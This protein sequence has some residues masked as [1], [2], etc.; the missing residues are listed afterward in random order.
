MLQAHEL[1]AWD[2]LRVVKIKEP[3]T[4]HTVSMSAGLAEL[5]ASTTVPEAYIML[6]TQNY[7][8]TLYTHLTAGSTYITHPAPYQQ[9]DPMFHY[10]STLTHSTNADCMQSAHTGKSQL[11]ALLCTP[12]HTAVLPDHTLHIVHYAHGKLCT[13]YA[14]CVASLGSAVGRPCCDESLGGGTTFPSC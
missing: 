6:Q 11:H 12:P 13:H 1:C 4:Q 14:C 8:V 10:T 5:S 7:T 2:A 9:A 3:S